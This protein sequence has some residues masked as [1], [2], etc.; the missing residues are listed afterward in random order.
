MYTKEK[1]NKPKGIKDEALKKAM[2]QHQVDEKG[3]FIPGNKAK[4]DTS[5]LAQQAKC[6]HL[7]SDLKWGANGKAT[8]ASCTKCGTKSVVCWSKIS[9]EE[10]E[11]VAESSDQPEPTGKTLKG[12][13][14]HEAWVVNNEKEMTNRHR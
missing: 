7:Y 3:N 11:P 2:Y 14:A 9:S 5:R 4:Y 1:P 10:D 6:K 13:K 8:Y 12:S